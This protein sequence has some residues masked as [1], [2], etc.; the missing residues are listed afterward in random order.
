MAS[1]YKHSES[2]AQ[3]KGITERIQGNY[4]TAQYIRVLDA[5]LLEGVDAMIDDTRYMDVVLSKV[6]AWSVPNFRRKVTMSGKENLVPSVLAFLL[7]K[8]ATKKKALLRELKLD[9]IVLFYALSSFLEL[10]EKE[11]LPAVN[12]ELRILVKGDPLAF[13]MLRVHDVERS[14]HASKRLTG[15]YAKVKYWY[16]HAVDFKHQILEKYTRL[17]LMSAQ[18]DYVGYFHHRVDLDDIVQTY[19]YMASRAIDK[20]DVNRGVLTTHILNWLLTGRAHL[21]RDEVEQPTS[22]EFLDEDTATDV[23]T[24]RRDSYSTVEHV[25]A[26]SRLIDPKGLGRYLLGIEQPVG[27]LLIHRAARASVH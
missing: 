23:D 19:L 21:R 22:D 10:L 4:S 6:L 5:F 27:E 20:C 12:G 18:R 15:T 1:Q 8:N 24:E 11:Y 14:L 26:V 17:C 3:L 13:C 25:Q 2:F 9:R 7:E 16:E